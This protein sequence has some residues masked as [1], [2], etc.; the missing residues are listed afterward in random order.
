MYLIRI[1]QIHLFIQINNLIKSFL[2]KSLSQENRLLEIE[3]F[4]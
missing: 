3:N 2:G 4:C 1:N